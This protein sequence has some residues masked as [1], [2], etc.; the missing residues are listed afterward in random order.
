LIAHS[1]STGEKTDNG[2]K[3]ASRREAIRKFHDYGSSRARQK[4]NVAKRFRLNTEDLVKKDSVSLKEDIASWGE[5]KLS[6]KQ[7]SDTNKRRAAGKDRRG[8][9]VGLGKRNSQEGEGFRAE[10]RGLA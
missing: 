4:L 2:N 7:S 1:D 6:K 5:R 8:T 10:T 3:G 9:N